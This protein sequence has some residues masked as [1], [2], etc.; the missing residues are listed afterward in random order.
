MSAL[1]DFYNEL[2][3]MF[4]AKGFDVI[5]LTGGPP[6]E[7]ATPWIYHFSN[8]TGGLDHQH[9]DTPEKNAACPYC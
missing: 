1:D 3:N 4:G 7:A 8:T 2:G 5:D 6:M 9:Q